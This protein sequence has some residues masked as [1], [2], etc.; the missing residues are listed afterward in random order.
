MSC[1][2]PVRC[3]WKSHLALHS[4]VQILAPRLQLIQLYTIEIHETLVYRVTEIGRRLLADD[5][6]YTT[7][8]FSIEFIV[9]GENCDL[10]PRKQLSQLKVWCA[11]LDA[12]L[13]C[14]VGTS[15]YATVVV[16]LFLN[17]DYSEYSL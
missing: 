11:L 3:D 9:R 8:Q 2:E 6:H 13:L 4:L 15:H 10:L 1:W 7:S 17:F 12:H 14:L 5:A 16:R